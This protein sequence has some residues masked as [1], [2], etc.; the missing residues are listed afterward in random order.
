MVKKE[1]IKWLPI[2]ML[3]SAFYFIP[4][5]EIGQCDI[6]SLAFMMWGIYYYLKN[7]TRKF[8]LFFAI[9][10]PIKYFP[11]MIFIPLV[12]LHEKNPIKIII[13]VIEGCSILIINILLRKI[14]FGTFLGEFATS[15]LNTITSTVTEIIDDAVSEAATPE[16]SGTVAG[17]VS[18]AV[19]T[20]TNAATTEIVREVVVESKSL[21]NF[22]GPFIANSSIFVVSFIL[23]CVF[24]YAIK[25]ENKQK[26]TIYISA[27]VYAAFFG[28]TSI[29]IYWTV[30]IMPF[31]ALLIFTNSS[32]LRLGMILETVAGWALTF[33]SVFKWSWLVGGEKTFSYLFLRGNE[34]G[35]DL[36]TF[37][38]SEC[39]LEGLS[40]YAYSAYVACM[41]GILA[42]NAPCFANKAENAGDDVKVDRWIIWIRIGILFV[43]CALLVYL[44]FMR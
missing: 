14:W 36:G 31:L 5:V 10:I 1:N 42:V 19:D 21:E 40:V 35:A 7:D 20:V 37:L 16:I 11:L 2:F 25:A 3:T 24:A 30:L 29:N 15:S 28:M 9:A 26:W 23:I 39:G 17:V 44:F 38:G 34:N 22:L 8:L 18:D 33:A 41:I 27:L 32:Q 13:Q 4:V 12:L 43:W 6:V